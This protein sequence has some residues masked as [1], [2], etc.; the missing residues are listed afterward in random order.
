M[1]RPSK[2]GNKPPP[3]LILTV[4]SQRAFCRL[5]SRRLDDFIGADDGPFPQRFASPIRLPHHARRHHDPSYRGDS[6]QSVNTSTMPQASIDAHGSLPALS[7]IESLASDSTHS[8]MGKRHL[9]D[10]LRTLEHRPDDSLEIDGR[11]LAQPVLQCPFRTL[12][13][14]LDYSNLDHWFWHTVGHFETKGSKL[15]Q[16]YATVIPPRSN[17]CCF[18]PMEFSHISGFAS[19]RMRMLHVA[20]HHRIGHSL[21]H[22]QPDFQFFDYLWENYLIDEEDYRE[23]KGNTPDGSRLTRG[24]PSPPTSD[25]SHSPP[26]TPTVPEGR[27]VAVLNERRH[28]RRRPR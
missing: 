10:R 2:G 21:S 17:R 7:S 28:D 18:C 8:S 27:P 14:M 15:A 12:G 22:A 26:I 19:W 3:L 24:I 9:S 13:C 6:P 25:P 4:P 1:S 16:G 11:P 23:L 5:L 20:Q